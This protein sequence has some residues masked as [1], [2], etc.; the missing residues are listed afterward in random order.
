MRDIEVV[1]FRDGCVVL[2]VKGHE[3]LL[4]RIAELTNMLEDV[5]NELDL[6]DLAI[7]QHGPLGTPPAELVGLV[8]TEKDLKIAALKAGLIEIQQEQGDE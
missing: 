1:K 5:V 4:A 3:N 7:E 8:L 2:T 6:S